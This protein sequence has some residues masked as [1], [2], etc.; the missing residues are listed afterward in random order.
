M[1]RVNDYDNSFLQ[2]ISELN[3]ELGQHVV[4]RG[5]RSFDNSL[6]ISVKDKVY[7]LSQVV[8]ENIFVQR[9]SRNKESHVTEN[10]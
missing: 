9:V 5:K 2:Y 10:N 8:A 1:V 3:I 6:L 7:S 4:V